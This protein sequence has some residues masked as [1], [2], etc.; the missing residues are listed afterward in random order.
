[1]E[2]NREST[3]FKA[4]GVI[5]IILTLFDG[6]SLCLPFIFARS[7]VLCGLVLVTIVS[8]ISLFSLIILSDISQKLGS[9]NYG[10]LVGIILG[11][12]ARKIF[13][14]SLFVFLF[15]L[16]TGFLVLMRQIS[17][18]VFSQLVGLE[19]ENS[20][21]YLFSLCLVVVELLMMLPLMMRNEMSTLRYVC[22][23]GFFSVCVLQLSLYSI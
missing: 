10:N 11:A 4:T 23:F 9:S 19:S 21:K 3:F 8:S 1:M 2:K 12:N 20:M 18:D 16:L 22:Y 14:M 15:M 7:G 17:S 5:S 6:T 13:L